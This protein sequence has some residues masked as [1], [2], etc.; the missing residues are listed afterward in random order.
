MPLPFLKFKISDLLVF[1]R[2]GKTTYEGLLLAAQVSSIS[3]SNATSPRGQAKTAWGKPTRLKDATIDGEFMAETDLNMTR[4]A[5]SRLH[6]PLRAM[7]AG[8]AVV[9]LTT[10]PSAPSNSKMRNSGAANRAY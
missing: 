2:F 8:T 9:H 10:S 4:P 1:T 7:G 6:P 3:I 5:P